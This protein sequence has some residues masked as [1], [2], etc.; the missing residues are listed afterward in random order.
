MAIIAV[1]CEKGGAA[2]TTTAMLMARDIARRGQTAIVLDADISG[3][4]TTWAQTAEE[5]GE[6]LPFP[7]I[8]VNLPQ[9][10]RPRIQTMAG[11]GTW[12]F[13]DTP[14][15]DTGVLQAAINAADLT[16][17]PTQTGDADLVL[18]LETYAAAPSA[19]LLL[20]RVKQRTNSAKQAMRRLAEE[21]IGRFDAVVPE[22]EAIRRLYGTDGYDKLDYPMVV[23]ELMDFMEQEAPRW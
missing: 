10:K 20:T 8:S 12:V 1:A 9:L 18:A 14:P 19:L 4:A 21:N 17:V 22:R 15:S 2:K 23:Q 5:N 16:I 13:I 7:V 11:K 6:K 3:G